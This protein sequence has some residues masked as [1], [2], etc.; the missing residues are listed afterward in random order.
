MEETRDNLVFRKTPETRR[1]L[2]HNLMQVI[3]VGVGLA[4]PVVFA[5]WRY[6][7]SSEP[8]PIQ[9]ALGW[10]ILSTPFSGGLW[11]SLTKIGRKFKWIT[12]LLLLVAA[13]IHIQISLYPFFFFPVFLLAEIY[14]IYFLFRKA[15]L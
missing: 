2:F 12:L 5:Y 3:V 9:D 4:I 14:A 10:G 6:R 7:T 13:P 11:L 1:A 8:N 15:T